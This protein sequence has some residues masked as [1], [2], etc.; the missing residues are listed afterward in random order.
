MTF[1]KNHKPKNHLFFFL[2]DRKMWVS[3][4]RI[5]QILKY[6]AI[7]RRNVPKKVRKDVYRAAVQFNMQPYRDLPSEILLKIAR[8]M[9]V[10]LKVKEASHVHRTQEIIVNKPIERP[11]QVGDIVLDVSNHQYS[12]D[13]KLYI[14][15]ESQEYVVDVGNLMIKGNV[16]D[17]FAN[18]IRNAP[19]PSSLPPTPPNN[20]S[21]ARAL[22][23]NFMV[24]LSFVKDD[25][26][27]HFRAKWYLQ[28][29][30]THARADGKGYFT[31]GHFKLL[32]TRVDARISV[33]PPQQL[34]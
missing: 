31:K 23:E 3:E 2:V 15:D 5:S 10:K 4:F 30:E 33:V 18:A 24:D 32:L 7:D 21:T 1:Q 13:F 11:I 14:S 19:L 20:M 29:I 28:P 27:F 25:T 8:H 26:T 17:N 34:Q 22:Q 16:L 12:I 6:R 9:D